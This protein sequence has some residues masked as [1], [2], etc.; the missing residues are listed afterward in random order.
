MRH[1]QEVSLGV[2]TTV[3]AVGAPGLLVPFGMIAALVVG[4]SGGLHAMDAH[5]TERLH[6]LALDH[7]V[8]TDSMVW[9]SL[10]FSPNAWR[11]G[12]LGLIVWLVKRRHAR[13]A[14]FWVAATMTA[15][16]V[17]GGVLKLL[18]GR[19]RPDL[20]DPVARATGFS[21]P[22]GHALNCALGAVVFLLVLLPEVRE[23]PLAKAALW[24]AAIGVPLVT[25]FTRVAIGVHWTSDVV[26][27]WL[28]G[29]A[30]PAV[31]VVIFHSRMA[32]VRERVTG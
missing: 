27:G 16:G 9:W 15:G 18:F 12:A 25:G 6:R 24:C 19:H 11:A 23:R 17:L 1:E 5:V 21:F 22:S 2:R 10:V 28:L 29:V 30:V 32:R 31:T 20:L 26:A 3:A 7:P 4:R 14:A 8:L 13:T